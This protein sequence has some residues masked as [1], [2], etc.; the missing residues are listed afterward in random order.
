MFEFIRTHQKLMQVLLALLIV[1]SFVLVGVGGYKSFGDE[2]NTI[3]NIDGHPLTRQEWEQAQRTQIDNYRQRMGAQFDQK[4][5]D[6]PEFRQSVLDQLIA[7]RSV[8]AE[9]A[10][11]HLTVTDGK[12]QKII[13][14]QIKDIPGIIK[15]D[16]TIDIEIY[17]KILAQGQGLTPE[18]FQ[19]RLR[20]DMTLQ[21]VTGSVALSG[22]VPRAVAKQLSD[23]SAQERE[24]QELALPA[25]QFLAQV[26]VTDEMVKAFYDKNAKMFETPESAKIEYVVFNAAAVMEQVSVTDA[27]IAAYYEGTKARYTAPEQRRASHILVGVKVGG[28]AADKAA[29]KAKAEAIL[30][31]VRK[32][33]ADFA[34]IAKAKSDDPTSADKGGDLDVL[35]KGAMPK[36]LEDA[37]FKLKQ[38]E[39]AGPIETEFG[40]HIVTVTSLK[41]AAVKP[42]EEVKVEIAEELKKQ[43]AAKKYSEMAEAFTNTVYEQADSLK[44]VA[45]KLK[46]KIETAEN[47]GRAPSPAAGTAPYNNA[48]FLTALY[49]NET[50]KNKR[51]TEAVE[52]APSTM[53]AGRVLE[54]K[55]AAKR[56]LAEVDAAI[57]QRVT[58]EEAVKLAKKEG[59]AKLATAK[60][61]GGAEGFSPAKLVSRANAYGMNQLALADVMKA[62]TSKLPAYVGVELPGMGYAVYRISK[63]QQPE[64]IDDAQ[65]KAEQE[66]ISSMVAQQELFMYVDALKHKA[67]VKI[68]GSVIA[69][70]K[71][72]AAN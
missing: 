15:A 33:P 25:Q 50:L 28:A 29:A 11:S 38:G 67:K 61:S 19:Q 23:F 8:G 55:A 21:Q 45:D 16:G 42:L 44:P 9:V 53:V 57:R 52:V 60:A 65:R 49:G 12:L 34:K 58:A 46:L 3:A 62:D 36:A 7:E 30:A 68:V 40:Y 51:N 6:T 64:K 2:A 59:E 43:K 69:P 41:A 32:A 63:V 4:L 39:V 56:P 20:R 17:R 5:F 18:G 37:V 24:V 1:P 27:D 31:D 10:R 71:T 66:Q 47:V 72:E 54:Y 13:V 35:E 70:V 48:K 14:D 26:K 22:F